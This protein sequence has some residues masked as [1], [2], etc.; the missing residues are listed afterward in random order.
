MIDFADRRVQ[1]GIGGAVA[2]LLLL[3]VAYVIGVGDFR[4]LALVLG[5]IAAGPLVLLALRNPY[6]F[7]YGL[8]ILL[9]PFD[10]LLSIGSAG[11]ITKFLGLA[12]TVFV[13]I[14]IIRKRMIMRPPLPLY[15]ALPYFGLVLLSI[16]WTPSIRT[17]SVEAPSI[18]SYVLMYAVLSLAPLD[19]AQLRTICSCILIGGV[20]GALYGMYMLAGAHASAPEN[21]DYGRLMITVGGHRID[22]NQ[23]ANALLGPIAIA[24]VWLTHTRNVA[25]A[26]ALVAAIGILAEGVLIS[27]SREALVAC[28]AVG[29]V[30]ILY[31]RR[32]VLGFGVLFAAA[33]ASFALVPAI[34][35][36]MMDAFKTG[37]AGRTGIWHTDI[38]AWAVHPV[39]GWG[40]GGAEDAYNAFLLRVAPRYFTGWGRPPHNTLLVALVELGIVGAVLVSAAYLSSFSL[41]RTI[42]RGSELFPTKVALTAALAGLGVAAMFIDLTV[43]KF[44]WVVVVGIAQLH[45]VAALDPAAARAPAPA[46]ARPPR[47]AGLVRVRGSLPTS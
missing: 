26:L 20:L 27:L 42:E 31:S 40:V 7:P 2:A 8:Y 13:L 29:V 6:L 33:A 46:P 22:P 12:A 24:V 16:M 1:L 35:G 37:G 10:Q 38:A 19:R 4:Q 17:A 5:L 23:F 44:L 39:F 18:S 11:T 34:A 47:Y 15:F 14:Y 25:R 32:R 28:L 9:I 36:R 30:I 21:A 43:Y 3:A 41:L 45:N